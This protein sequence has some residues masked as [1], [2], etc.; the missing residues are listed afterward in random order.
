[1][2][3]SLDKAP[4]RPSTAER[5]AAE[6][7]LRVATGEGRID[8]DEFGERLRVVM[9]TPDR[10]E[11]ERVVADIPALPPPRR[12]RGRRRIPRPVLIGAGVALAAVVVFGR[13]LAGPDTDR[14]FALMGGNVS[15]QRGLA[16]GEEV[17]VD[18]T[19][20]MGGVEVLVNPG[21]RVDLDAFAIMGGTNCDDSVCRGQALPANAPVVRVQ[22]FALMGGIEV[23]DGSAQASSDLD[24]AIDD[25]RDATEEVRDA[26]DAD[27]A[28]AQA[29]LEAAQN[30]LRELREAAAPG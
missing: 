2:S 28:E 18:A 5:Q 14:A 11:L 10:G 13:G 26:D 20:I 19:A 24:E 3:S 22:G 12:P 23:T 25:V 4:V 30:R 1:M 16:P 27:R 15:D 17:V 29:Q 9:S 8:L 6:E 21:T 7:R